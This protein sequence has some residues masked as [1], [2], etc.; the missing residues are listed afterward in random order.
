MF[1]SKVSPSVSVFTGQLSVSVDENVLMCVSVLMFCLCCRSCFTDDTFMCL[2]R[3]EP[4][5]V[6]G[7]IIPVSRHGTDSRLNVPQN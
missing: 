6:C 1:I 7:A 4:V 3:H 2:T 5:G